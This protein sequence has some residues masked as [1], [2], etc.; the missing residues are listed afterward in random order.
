MRPLIGIPCH[1]GTRAG[2]D[3]PI[4]Y[5]NRSYIHAVERAGGVPVLIPIYENFSGMHVLLSRLDGLLISGGIDVDPGN[6]HEA[7]H[8]NLSETNPPLDA[9]EIT[10]ARWAVRKQV[11]TL[12]ICR[13]MQLLNVAHGGSLIQ[14]LGD[15]PDIL[16]HG[17]WD[18]PRNTIVHHV[19]VEPGSRLEYILGTREVPVN[20]LHHQAVKLAGNGV[21]IS[22]HAE[23]NVAEL[24]EVP[25][26]PFMLGAQC[27]PEELFDTEP[28]WIRLFSAF[29]EACVQAMAQKITAVSP[30]E[31]D[32]H[33]IEELEPLTHLNSFVA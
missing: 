25:D 17:N 30:L 7:P 4:Y 19:R 20:S 33:E 1:A 2:T 5:N 10:L 16:R 26:H 22:G 21:Y 23:D 24:L 9:M 12:G 14:H 15:I 3:R 31:D 29:I 32:E 13:G 18:L 8:P 6:Y 11:P 27:H 28:V